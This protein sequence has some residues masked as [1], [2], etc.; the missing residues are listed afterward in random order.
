ME[1]IETLGPGNGFKLYAT[2]DIEN[3]RVA[4]TRLVENRR[5]N[6]Q[7]SESFHIYCAHK[8]SNIVFSIKEGNHVGARVIGRAYM[9]VEEIVNGAEVDRWL[10]ILKKNHKPLRGVPKIHVK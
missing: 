5:S 9:P 4:R 6:P 7:W 1:S 10:K 3:A 8:A 2:L